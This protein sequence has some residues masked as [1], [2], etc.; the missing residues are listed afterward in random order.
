MDYMNFGKLRKAYDSAR[1]AYP[2]EVMDFIF[3]LVDKSAKILDVGCGTG[4][5]TRQLADKIAKISGCDIDVKMI[6]TAQAHEDKIQYYVA[7]TKKMPFE[8]EEFD[9]ITSFGAFHW[10]CGDDSVSE[11]KRVLK[12]GGFFI[13]VNKNEAG[14]FRKDYEEIIEN[15]TGNKPPQ[16]VKAEYNPAS[17][18]EQNGFSEIKKK[19]FSHIEKFSILRAMEQI[20]SMSIW[21]LIPEAKKISALELFRNNFEKSAKNGVVHR[22]LEIV[23]V[24]GKK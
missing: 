11:I 24:S 5:A 7:P 16:S 1:H 6:E 9:A 13:I 21:N 22:Q 19:K 2:Q 10:F 23:V 3:S 4:I 8:K 17:I 20:Q 14:N 18:L 15:L 12:S